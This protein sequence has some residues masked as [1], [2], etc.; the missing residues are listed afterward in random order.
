[1]NAFV[2]D[3]EAQFAAKKQRISVPDT[4]VEYGPYSEFF[5]TSDR[6]A[7]LGWLGLGTRIKAGQWGHLTAGQVD[8]A[9]GQWAD[10]E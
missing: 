10:A 3:L 6:R 5:Q 7:R 9:L 8:R 4:K 1:M 2:Q